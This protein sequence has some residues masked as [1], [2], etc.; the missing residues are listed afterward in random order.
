MVKTAMQIHHFVGLDL[1]LY[2][3]QCHHW[4]AAACECGKINHIH[5]TCVTHIRHSL[6]AQTI[7]IQFHQTLFFEV[8]HHETIILSV[9]LYSWQLK[10]ARRLP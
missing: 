5:F 8:G 7:C 6:R 2:I 9:S 3:K 1:M 10:R 4:C